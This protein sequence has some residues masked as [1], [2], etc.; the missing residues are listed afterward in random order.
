MRQ[1]TRF[2][3]GD[4]CHRRRDMLAV[5]LLRCTRRSPTVATLLQHNVD[6]RTKSALG[7]KRHR[8]D[9][10]DLTN[11]A[12]CAS[13][14]LDHSPKLAA[15]H[16]NSGRERSLSGGYRAPLPSLT[17]S[18][19]RSILTHICRSA[20]AQHSCCQNAERGDT[21]HVHWNGRTFDWSQ[22]RWQLSTRDRFRSQFRD[23]PKT[24][25]LVQ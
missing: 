18:C 25:I 12:F 6:P 11:C 24:D 10:D 23:G 7:H 17:W 8:L 20:D 4:V 5:R 21:R 19:F 14:L 3:W 1:G 15:P 13:H 9:T 2:K 16:T 22:Q